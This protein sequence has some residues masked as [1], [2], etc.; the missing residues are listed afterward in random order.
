MNLEHLNI[1]YNFDI[2][3]SQNEEEYA[4]FNNEGS[5]I[6]LVFP[7]ELDFTLQDSYIIRYITEHPEKLQGIKLNLESSKILNCENKKGFKQCIVPK[8]HLFH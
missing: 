7:E 6:S 3:N 4:I 5:L 8:D 1:L 2:V